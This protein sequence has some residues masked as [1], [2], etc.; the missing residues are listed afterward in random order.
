MSDPL[1]RMVRKSPA[2]APVKIAYGGMSAEQAYTEKLG[3]LFR[4]FRT[5]AKLLFRATR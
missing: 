2:C 5:V 3:M 1:K 4:F